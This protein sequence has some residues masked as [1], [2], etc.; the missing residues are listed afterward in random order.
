MSLLNGVGGMLNDKSVRR[1]VRLILNF[2]FAFR[3]LQNLEKGFNNLPFY[4]IV[5]KDNK[6]VEFNLIV[7]L[8]KRS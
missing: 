3:E 4:C 1:R 2:G 7:A 6:T 5:G 8:G